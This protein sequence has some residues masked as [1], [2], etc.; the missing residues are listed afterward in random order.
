MFKEDLLPEAIDKYEI[1][2]L[3]D[4]PPI[5]IHRRKGESVPIFGDQF[6]VDTNGKEWIIH[7]DFYGIYKTD[8]NIDAYK[9]W[10]KKFMEKLERTYI[11]ETL[12]RHIEKHGKEG[13]IWSEGAESMETD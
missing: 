10:T 6:A 9:I 8:E 1:K 11:P 13:R 4:M 3:P 2:P 7:E 5:F 12:E